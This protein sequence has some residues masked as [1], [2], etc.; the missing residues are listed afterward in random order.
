MNNENENHSIFLSYSRLTALECE[1][2]FYKTYL[3][4]NTDK[5]ITFTQANSIGS[6]VHDALTN[7]YLDGN[8]SL[9]LDKGIY[10]DEVIELIDNV[11]NSSYSKKN[12]Y[13]VTDYDESVKIDKLGI[14]LA[15]KPDLILIDDAAVN[16]VEYKTFT[17]KFTM[18]EQL[19]VYLYGILNST[20]D[21]YKIIRDAIN[22]KGMV[23]LI[24]HFLSEDQIRTEVI[25]QENFSSFINMIENRLL[26]AIYTIEKIESNVRNNRIENIKIN[27]KTAFCN[28]CC[29]RG[30]CPA[31]YEI[32]QFINKTETDITASTDYV[33]MSPH[34]KLLVLNQVRQKA[35][36]YSKQIDNYLTQINNEFFHIINTMSLT[37]LSNES[38]LVLQTK[39]KVVVDKDKTKALLKE[40]ELSRQQINRL[41]DSISC[42]KALL[43]DLGI[44]MTGLTKTIYKEE[45][46]YKSNDNDDNDNY[47]T[48]E[49]KW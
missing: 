26:N 41:I 2:G 11:L 1:Y 44:D 4:T 20:S 38:M 34:E 49:I 35:K 31:S 23:R 36:Y 40:I 13:I 47:P 9:A 19:Y 25:Y 15:V 18:F 46:V 16:I 21:K 27:K 32:G 24:Y 48:T 42:S 17:M 14:T 3:D 12:S 37:E 7:L 6:L 39:K 8:H 10:D 43:E 28:Y 29:V 45:Y 5:S 33:N 30:I 22:E